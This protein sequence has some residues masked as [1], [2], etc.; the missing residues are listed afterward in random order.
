MQR[1]ILIGAF[2]II[3]S[4]VCIYS[5]F[6]KAALAQA[7]QTSKPQSERAS[8]YVLGW[9]DGEKRILGR[10]H[11]PLTIKVSP[12]TGSQQ[13]I[14]GTE[15]IAAGTGIPV[16]LHEHEDEIIFIHRGQ[17]TATVGN[18]AVPVNEGATIYIPRGTWH[19][20]QNEDGTQPIDMLWIFSQPGMDDFFRDLSVLYGSPLREITPKEVEEADRKHGMRR[21]LP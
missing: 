21:K 1:I 9:D 15:Q 4:V 5:R 14:M 12:K 3:L 16:H 2:T 18:N 7:P 8:G 10:R 20:V 13:L 17:G 19:A 11:A 6:P